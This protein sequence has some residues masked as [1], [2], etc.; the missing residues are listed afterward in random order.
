MLPNAH[1]C[2]NPTLFS[3]FQWTA[4]SFVCNYS[5]KIGSWFRHQDFL[6]HS[7]FH[8]LRKY[9]QAQE[10]YATPTCLGRKER[11]QIKKL[12]MSTNKRHFLPLETPGPNRRSSVLHLP[13]QWP[14]PGT[15]RVCS[16][17]GRA[18]GLQGKARQQ[19]GS[20]FNYYH[21]VNVTSGYDAEIK[22]FTVVNDL[23]R[24]QLGKKSTSKAA[25]CHAGLLFWYSNY[26]TLK[27][28]TARR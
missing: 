15:D 28:V 25:N 22:F 13:C 3:C 26:A 10:H 2:A 9:S 18:E 12:I 20:G 23:F 24:E 5:G 6:L 21:A 1:L 27:F 11:D 16:T 14:S 17:W 19:Q 8:S 7:C 4:W